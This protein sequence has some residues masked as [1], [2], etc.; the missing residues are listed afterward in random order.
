MLDLDQIAK[1][2]R[3][4][5]EKADRLARSS[6][7]EKLAQPDSGITISFQRAKQGGFTVNQERRGPD[8]EAID[9]FVL[10]FRFF[11]QD[12]EQSSFRNMEKHYL[13]ASIDVPLQK[14]FTE[15]RKQ[16]NGYLDSTTNITFNGEALT[17]RRIMDVFLYGGLSHG[18]DENKRRLHKTWVTDPISGVMFEHEFI[19]ILGK[20]FVAIMMIKKM[21]AK[22][23]EHL[24]GPS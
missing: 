18:W 6:F 21:N 2:L 8:E 7:L 17:R 11:I 1:A 5:N 10:T 4:F 24:P 19:D 23:L 14:Q 15:L 12:R 3:L 22:A 16:V 20:L 9:A 13:S